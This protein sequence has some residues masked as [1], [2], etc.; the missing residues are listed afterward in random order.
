MTN[1]TVINGK[2]FPH[3]VVFIGYILLLLGAFF[4]LL[5]PIV[6]I[7]FIGIGALVAFSNYGVI[8]NFDKKTITEFTAYFGCWKSKKVK[9]YN[10]HHYIT[11][12]PVNESFRMY[13]RSSIGTTI[14]D[15][16]FM[17][18]IFDEKLHRKIE[19][20]KQEKN[21]KAKEIALELAVK[22]ELE[23]VDYDPKWIR[24]KMRT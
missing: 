19:V 21:A 22:M 18:T 6:S 8:L 4:L 10:D 5:N 9:S 2:S 1:E 24:E 16:F 11:V 12:L 17:I 15:Y 20:S 13:S 14:K 23:Y 3:N 7:F